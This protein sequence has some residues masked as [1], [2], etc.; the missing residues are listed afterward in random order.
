[1]EAG[2]QA[3]RTG[4]AVGSRGVS[5]TPQR[6]TLSSWADEKGEGMLLEEGLGQARLS[7][8]RLVG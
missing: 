8:P 1:M 4:S 6:F 5:V 2:S 3:I 7:D